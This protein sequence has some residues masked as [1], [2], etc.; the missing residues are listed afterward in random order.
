MTHATL[1]GIILQL[2]TGELF[3]TA[4]IFVRKREE[5]YLFTCGFYFASVLPA[6]PLKIKKVI[7]INIYHKCWI[8]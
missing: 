7:I 1:G 4:E 2:S 5:G 3:S 8:L 6:G